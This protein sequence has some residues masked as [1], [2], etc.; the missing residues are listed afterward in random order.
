MP[1][2]ADMNPRGRALSPEWAADKEARKRAARTL[3]KLREALDGDAAPPP[4]GLDTLLLGT[5]NIR[6]FDSSTWGDRIPESYA[7][8]A[9]IVDRF[10]LVA[11]QEVRS[12]LAAL[13]KLQ[14]RLGRHWSYLVSDVTRGRS[15]NQERLAFLYDTRKVQF[16]GMAGELVLPPVKPPKPPAGAGAAAAQPK[17]VPAQQVARTPLMAAFQVGWT[18]FILSTVHILYGPSTAAPPERIEEIRQVARFL[19]AR[20]DDETEDI[21]NFIVLGDFNIFKPEDKTMEA[22]TKDG[23]FSVPDGMTSIPGTNVDKNKKYDQIAYRARG[24]RFASTGKAGFF[25]FYEHVFTTADAD[26]YRPYIDAY[27][28]K[29]HKQGKKSPKMPDSD[30]GKRSQYKKWRTYQMSD[31]LPLWAEFQIDFADDYLKDIRKA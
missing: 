18:R 9:E 13:R 3:L 7:Y 6:E 25:D 23:G 12:N 22:L 31:H 5:W 27:I 24:D 11:V 8:I 4:R 30:S 29:R 14:F 16:L 26:T 17:E 1:Y 15:G 20:T 19:R 21:R 2:Y 28:A 10:D